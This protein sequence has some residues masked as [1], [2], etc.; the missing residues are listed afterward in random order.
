[1]KKFPHKHL[2]DTIKR[3][4]WLVTG[5]PTVV[6]YTVGLID[7]HS[8]PEL[9]IQGLPMEHAY[10]VLF[11]AQN[12][13]KN[14]LRFDEPGVRS[15]LIKGYDAHLVEV[16]RSNY[17]DWLG[18]AHSYHGAELRAI[19]ILW[20][21]RQRRFPGQAGFSLPEFPLDVRQD[22]DAECQRWESHSTGCQCHECG[23][24]L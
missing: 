11:E 17:R 2:N 15:G 19:Q 23:K 16:H 4:G 24:E 7:L 12:L 8:H 14:G 6:T 9:V 18:M 5:V 13:I 21:D 22:Y 20:P 3:V 1:M 10:G